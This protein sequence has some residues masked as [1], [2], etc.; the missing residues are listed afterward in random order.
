MMEEDSNV[1]EKERKAD[2][3]LFSRHS[4]LSA[5]DFTSYLSLCGLKTLIRFSMSLLMILNDK[6]L[7]KVCVIVCLY[8]FR[9]R[10]V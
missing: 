6:D 2:E 9:S 8:S 7:A 1:L 10:R 4:N 5:E 3:L